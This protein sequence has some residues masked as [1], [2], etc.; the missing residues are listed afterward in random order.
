[1]PRA[2]YTHEFE[3]EPAGEEHWQ[4][5]SILVSIEIDYYPGCA[6]QLYGPPERCYPA[7]PP[8]LYF[9]KVTI[10]GR[11]VTGHL[12]SLITDYI[13]SQLDRLVEEYTDRYN[14]EDFDELD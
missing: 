5:D 2:T 1:M 7:E 4:D 11:E 9:G 8:E 3:W 10:D 6:A 14:E 12:A 13:E